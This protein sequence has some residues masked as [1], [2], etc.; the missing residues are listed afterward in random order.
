MRI[1]PNF[2]FNGQ[3]SEAIQLYQRA[4]NAKVVSCITN[5][6]AT[7][8]EKSHTLSDAENR[9]YHAEMEIRDQR[10][11]MCDNGDVPFQ[12]TASLSLTVI[13]DTKEDLLHAYE[14]MKQ[15]GSIIYPVQST[16]YCSCFV[17]FF[18]RFGFRWVLMT[19]CVD[20]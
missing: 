6:E 10:V 12:P 20:A 14:I 16:S 2:N 13:F 4:F 17:S 8:E 3:C 5:K 19:E 9:I 11:M 1:I 18:D 15:G 7:W